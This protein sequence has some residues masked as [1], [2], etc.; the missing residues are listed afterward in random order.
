[1]QI[2]FQK[3]EEKNQSQELNRLIQKQKRKENNVSLRLCI[4]LIIQVVVV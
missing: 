2:L 1:M 4:L 3:N